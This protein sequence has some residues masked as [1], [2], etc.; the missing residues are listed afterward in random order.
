M[1]I[2]RINPYMHHPTQLGENII[3]I[4]LFFWAL[5]LRN[6]YFSVAVDKFSI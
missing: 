4:F 1:N 5:K 6:S 3:D 2:S